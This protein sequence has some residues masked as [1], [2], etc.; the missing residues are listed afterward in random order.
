MTGEGGETPDSVGVWPEP[1][2][3][4]PLLSGAWPLDQGE[5]E[6]EVAIEDYYSIWTCDLH[7]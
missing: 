2:P 6:E 3:G 5:G 4:D 1:G 7:V